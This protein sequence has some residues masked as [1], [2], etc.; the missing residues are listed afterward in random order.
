MLEILHTALR[1]RREGRENPLAKAAKGRSV[2]G[3]CRTQA[4]CPHLPAASVRAGA[5]RRPGGAPGPL[6]ERRGCWKAIDSFWQRQRGKYFDHVTPH[7][8]TSSLRVCNLHGRCHRPGTPPAPCLRPP[9]SRPRVPPGECLDQA[10]LRQNSIYI[11]PARSM[12]TKCRAP[13]RYLPHRSRP[14]CL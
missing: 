2:P 9:L 12:A 4:R 11:S 10:Q 7:K 6:P 13:R 8:W 3:R 5:S 14:I 1:L